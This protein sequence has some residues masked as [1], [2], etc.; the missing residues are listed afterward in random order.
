MQQELDIP[1]IEECGSEPHGPVGSTGV[2]DAR[3]NVLNLYAGLGGN[4]KKWEN[5]NVTA[6]EMEEQIA[7]VY[8]QQHPDDKVIVGDAHEYL[9]AHYAEYDFIW[10]SPPCQTHSRMAKATRHPLKRYPDMSLYQQILFLQH[11]AKGKW[12]V[13]NVTPYYEPLIPGHRVGRHIFWANFWMPVREIKTPRGFMEEGTLEY[14]EKL[15]AWLGIQYE[16]AIYYKDNH[17]PMQVLRNCVHPNVG[18]QILQ[19]ARA[20]TKLLPPQ[21]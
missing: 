6:V 12:V 18:A 14:A 13:E 17:D 8:R 11:Y 20:S 3:W 7:D 1:L 2:V 21:N 4:R 5:V 10:T 9:L 15:K 19:A 16:G